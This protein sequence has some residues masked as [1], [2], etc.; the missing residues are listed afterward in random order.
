MEAHVKS[1]NTDKRSKKRIRFASSTERSKRASA[2]VY[3]SY[4]RKIG[5]T[6]AATREEL[7]HNPSGT[8][9]SKKRQRK[10][11][12]PIDGDSRTAVVKVSKEEDTTDSESD[13]E[14][15]LSSTFAM[16]LDVAIDRNA[17]EVFSKFHRAV[18][19]LVR[20]LPEILHH[21]EKIVDLMMS[22]MLSPASKPERP[23]DL[24]ARGQKRE[25]FILN[26]ATTDILHLLSVLARDLRHE[27]HEYLH[28]KILPRIIHDL[29]NPPPPPTDSGKQPIPLDVTLVE[30]AFRTLSYIFRY[31]S[32]T[33]EHDFEDMRKYY[34]VTLANRREL[35][36][37]LAAETFAPMIRRLKSVKTTQRH[38][39][40][41]L[42]ALSATDA[43]PTT[44]SLI[45]TQ[46]EGVDGI[47]KLFFQLVKGTRGNVH[48]R[49][50]HI[51]CFLFSY[52]GQAKDD[53]TN[54]SNGLVFSVVSS[55]LGLLCYHIRDENS[56]PLLS[57]I[58]G[59]LKA[60]LTT[61]RS[62]KD[63]NQV[64]YLEP[65]YHMVELLEQIALV[66][67]GSIV[68]SQNDRELERLASALESM[69]VEGCFFSMPNEERDRVLSRCCSIWI[70]VQDKK[71][72]PQRMK[73]VLEHVFI[74]DTDAS[75]QAIQSMR[76]MSRIIS[77]ELLSK[78]TAPS[79][80]S[81]A[82]MAI[83]AGAARL[84][85]HDHESAL[86]LVLPIASHK[87]EKN[88]ENWEAGVDDT[89]C[90]FHPETGRSWKFDP[91]VKNKLLSNCCKKPTEQ[92]EFTFQ[93]L[94]QLGVALRCAPFLA[95]VSADFETPD[96]VKGH[97]KKMSKWI[98]GVLQFLDEA[99]PDMIEGAITLDLV[100]VKALA[101]EA[102][103]C[104]A[105]AVSSLGDSSMAEHFLSKARGNAERLLFADAKSVW[106]LRGVA[107]VLRLLKRFEISFDYAPDEV[108]EALMPNL[109]SPNHFLRLYSL[110][111]LVC[112][113]KKAF[114]TDHADLDLDGDL[115]EE[116]GHPRSDPISIR[117]G[118]T[119]ICDLIDT[120]LK[121]ER[122]PVCLADERVLVSTASKVETLGRTGKLPVIYAEAAAN[123]MLGLFHVKFSPL[124][125]VAS[126]SLLALVESHEKIVWPC[127]ETELAAVMKYA[128]TTL[129]DNDS[130]TETRCMS[131][132]L[133]H[134]AACVNWQE[135]SGK[136][137][138]VF[139]ASSLAEK[140][141]EVPR[142]L[143]T[144]MITVMESVWKVAEEG[145]QF[146]ARNS[147]VVVPIFISFLHREYFEYYSNDPEKRELHLQECP[148]EA[149]R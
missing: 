19:A 82:G 135:S 133:L 90:L 31:D 124:W 100:I 80:C 96:G 27:I 43:Q 71:F 50:H 85:E 57:E 3:R 22:Y 14:L 106:A 129:S 38:L 73:K 122:L 93:H 44:S 5:V 148:A 79:I 149:D 12:R 53:K 54:G 1:I 125:D 13:G 107:S 10:S 105:V 64:S 48:S 130:A 134:H 47:A 142:H 2:D 102:V 140:D 76:S 110:E 86:L 72:A 29:L 84:A 145:Q 141:G 115:D 114:V 116:A 70:K 99:R 9:R 83:V 20:S 55:F 36:R 121:L 61:F 81:A 132:S 15:E 113:P 95:L 117:S 24:S 7:V 123:H 87:P 75:S 32:K 59:N 78:L 30:A 147:R 109:R 91:S 88:E 11:H 62:S 74:R 136:D 143:T 69:F 97:Y 21:S 126:R 131:S 17:S 41:V 112:L 28:E 118:P 128:L 68:R 42:R 104:F 56:E 120:M 33:L 139:M 119:G 25:H 45:R 49:G 98:F 39:R 8:E 16:E 18:W 51:I 65:I 23:S 35:I 37:R 92:S 101:L 146:F 137:V 58:V 63:S 66:R 127:L 111:I 108:F 40:R 4:K 60:A 34:G 144:D 26:H 52:C 6:S 103:A 46:R 89:A 67:S 94:R 77:E 138:S